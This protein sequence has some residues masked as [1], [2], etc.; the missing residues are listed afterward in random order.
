VKEKKAKWVCQW[1]KRN[2]K[3]SRSRV[4]S[5]LDTRF[6]KVRGEGKKNKKKQK[7]IWGNTKRTLNSF[8]GQK[9]GF[10]RK[11]RGGQRPR[12]GEKKGKRGSKQ[13]R[14]KLGLFSARNKTPTEEGGKAKVSHRGGALCRH[15][16]PGKTAGKGLEVNWGGLEGGLQARTKERNAR[17]KRGPKPPSSRRIR[18]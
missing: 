12:K 14:H 16:H 15:Y 7:I 9:K 2:P 1:E 18:G 8:L 13:K 17:I 6:S 3:D 11:T 5:P 4:G 10:P